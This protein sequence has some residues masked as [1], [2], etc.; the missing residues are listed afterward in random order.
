M[1]KIRDYAPFLY[2]S[3]KIPYFWPF[4]HRIPIPDPFDRRINFFLGRKLWLKVHICGP[5]KE[6]IIGAKRQ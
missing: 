3:T 2:A 1:I 6:L 4:S 5:K